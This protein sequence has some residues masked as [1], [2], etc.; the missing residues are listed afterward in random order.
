MAAPGG[1]KN[2]WFR[3]TF[4]TQQAQKTPTEATDHHL[5]SCRVLAASLHGTVGKGGETPPLRLDEVPVPRMRLLSAL[6]FGHSVEHWYEAAFWALLPVFASELGLSLAEVGVLAAARAF[7]S[8]LVHMV[9]GALSDLIGRPLLLLTVCLAWLAVGFFAMGLAPSFP[10][11]L[12]LCGGMGA[13]V[14]LWHPPAMAVISRVYADR[15]GF[16]LSAHE[17]AGNVAN[18]I[19]PTVIGLAVVAVSWRLV[20]SAHLLPGL[21]VALVFWIGMPRVPT[22]GTARLELG[23]YRDAMRVL[24]SNPTVL[25]M[26]AVSALRTGA[27][28]ALNAFLPIYLAYTFGMTPAEYGPYLSALLALGILSPLVGGAVSD[29]FGRRPVLLVG[30]IVAGLL[31]LLLPGTAPGPGLFALLAAVGLFLYALR[32]VIFA[33]ALDVSAGGVAASA[34][35]FIFGIQGL[36]A[37]LAPAALGYVALAAGPASPL[38][39][40]GGL[41]L[42][43]AAVV[44]VVPR[45]AVRAAAA[46]SAHS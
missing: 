2:G 4:S 20:L 40:A 44:L 34:V 31:C 24:L 33:Y 15:R 18:L 35:G 22:G 21:L 1:I 9:S 38:A 25:G 19:T 37:G 12:L 26:S 17:L 7:L 32:S 14:G 23:A 3:I 5:G 36:V 45:P 6:S 27:Q 16:A 8:A 30:L 43:A 41:A 11:L 46:P 39:A 28:T 42:A 13:A 29:R 10:S